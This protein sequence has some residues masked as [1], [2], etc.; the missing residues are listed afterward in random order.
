MDDLDSNDGDKV[1]KD[2]GGSASGSSNAINNETPL[3]IE[4]ELLRGNQASLLILAVSMAGFLYTLDISIIVTVSL[5]A[6][7]EIMAII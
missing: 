7:L 1:E 2:E 6:S 3:E 4:S 5:A